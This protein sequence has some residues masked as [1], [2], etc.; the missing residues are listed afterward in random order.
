MLE[1]IGD[2]EQEEE[3]ENPRRSQSSSIIIKDKKR[4]KVKRAH[5]IYKV[6]IGPTIGQACRAKNI[7]FQASDEFDE[8]EKNDFRKI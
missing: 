4:G 7:D 6:E 1:W 8:E 3:E 5:I 2:E